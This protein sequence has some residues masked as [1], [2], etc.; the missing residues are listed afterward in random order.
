MNH[1][2]RER[3]SDDRG[4]TLAEILIAVAIIGIAFGALALT[5]VT[6]LQVNAESRR[7]SDTTEYAND[8]LEE[9]TQT[10]LA[11]FATVQTSCPSPGSCSND[12]DD[13]PFQGTV[14]WGTVGNGYLE[15]GLVEITVSMT[16]PSTLSFSRVVSCIDVNPPPSVA[17]P[18]PC[19]E[20]VT[21]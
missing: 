19:P 11:D 7:A 16:A 6:T 10:I 18:G 4:L 1:H 17:V 14:S 20:P 13:D 21:P 5:Q 3:R 2:S 15:E 8:V 9:R 12:I